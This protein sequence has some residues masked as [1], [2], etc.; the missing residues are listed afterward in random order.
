[1]GMLFTVGVVLVMTGVWGAMKISGKRLKTAGIVD[2]KIVVHYIQTGEVR[3]GCTS[4]LPDENPSMNLYR[5]TI[6]YIGHCIVCEAMYEYQLAFSDIESMS[7]PSL[8]YS[9]R[10]YIMY[11]FLVFSNRYISKQS[12]WCIPST[13]QLFGLP[14]KFGAG[15]AP[16]EPQDPDRCPQQ[17][18]QPN[19][20][21][22]AKGGFWPRGIFH[23]V[24]RSSPPRP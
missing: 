13:Y 14:H 8:Y 11:Y 10:L 2:E 19:Y 16:A 7:G 23:K 18:W 9:S 3:N 1:M 12:C 4:P 20:Q 21:T 24:G 22:E 17:V 6:N 5:S 15:Q